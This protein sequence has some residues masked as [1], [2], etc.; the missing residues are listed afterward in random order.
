MLPN[1][2]LNF[3]LSHMMDKKIIRSRVKKN[4]FRVYNYM[5]KHIFKHKY[6]IKMKKITI[7]VTM[8]WTESLI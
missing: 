8:E 5:F 1:I 6:N 3:Q 2:T 4:R 7:S